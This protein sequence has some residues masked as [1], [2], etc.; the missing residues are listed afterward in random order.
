MYQIKVRH[1]D[2]LEWV[3]PMFPKC[4]DTVEEL[5]PVM[6]DMVHVYDHVGIFDSNGELIEEKNIDEE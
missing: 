1:A 3:V 6:N 5:I 4:G 2:T